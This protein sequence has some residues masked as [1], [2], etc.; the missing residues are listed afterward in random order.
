MN[1]KTI[2]FNDSMAV[3]NELERMWKEAVVTQFKAFPELDLW[4]CGKSKTFSVPVTTQIPVRCIT[5]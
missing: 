1:L 4:D 3:N 5:T 2:A